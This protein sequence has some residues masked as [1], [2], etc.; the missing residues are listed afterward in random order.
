MIRWC[1]C[2]DDL[3]CMPG[4]EVSSTEALQCDRCLAANRHPISASVP[5]PGAARLFRMPSIMACISSPLVSVK[6]RVGLVVDELL[7][8]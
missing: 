6:P 8:T 1:G 3:E 7:R 4:K 5:P 2:A